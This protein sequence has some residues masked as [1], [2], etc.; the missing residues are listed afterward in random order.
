MD[1][2]E[3]G[4]ALEGVRC[5]SIRPASAAI[6]D[7]ALALITPQTTSSVAAVVAWRP[8]LHGMQRLQSKL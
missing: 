4:L 2:T 8:G 1:A 3:C 5:E 7:T 6:Q